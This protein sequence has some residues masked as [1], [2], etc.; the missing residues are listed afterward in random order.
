MYPPPHMTHMYP[1]PHMTHMYPPP[2]L[3]TH[4]TRV[5]CTSLLHPSLYT[6]TSLLYPW[7]LFLFF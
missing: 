6:Y 2:T 4:L 7:L 1:P 3:H 5:P